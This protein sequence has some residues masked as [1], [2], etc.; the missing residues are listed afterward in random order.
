MAEP[1]E[2]PRAE[3][4]GGT[5]SNET[6][7]NDTPANGE[8]GKPPIVMGYGLAALF[9]IGGGIT[10]A[11]LYLAQPILYRIKADF[12]LAESE[13]GSIV[14]LEQ[15]GYAAGLLFLTP[16]G[17]LLPRKRL[18]LV[19]TVITTAFNIL[20]GV[21]VNFTMFQIFSFLLGLSTVTPQILMPFAADIAPP[22]KR[23]LLM[24]LV[25]TGMKV[26]SLTGRLIS[27]IVTQ[28][29]SWRVVFLG[30]GVL[31]GLL[32]VFYLFAMPPTPPNNQDI[33]YPK[34]LWSLVTLARTQPALMQSSFISF[35]TFAIFSAFWTCLTFLLSNPPYNYS[36]STIG[37]FSL[38]G[39]VGMFFSTAAGS[40]ADRVG[41]MRLIGFGI[42]ATF[43]VWIWFTPTAPMSIA[44]VVIG[45]FAQEVG[46]QFIHLP[47]QV[48]V[49][50]L[51][52]KARSRLNSVYM[53]IG[54]VGMSV[55][56]VVGVQA[57]VHGGWHA[58][59][60]T[61]LGFGGAAFLTWLALGEDG[62]WRFG[63]K[64][65][66]T[67]D[68]EVGKVDKG[69]EEE[70]ALDEKTEVQIAPSSPENKV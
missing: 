63:K 3:T 15:G 56:S 62:S 52:P 25:L 1:E 9:A 58:V 69:S 55:G 54:F 70:L 41:P 65:R 44:A 43:S 24:G 49:F 34:L 50:A 7:S 42:M 48:R 4:N 5:A 47:N 30:Q 11:N 18:I 36:T 17:D 23:G 37:L 57:W 64:E 67:A 19:L 31:N 38:I 32:F 14:S 45:C 46:M 27:G 6:P 51:V 8:P 40:I 28:Y 2:P 53:I 59:G 21:S 68:A 10:V 61:S 60:Y 33:S 26:G 12:H 39:I 20:R 13:A 16:L 66:P 22:A 35:F 29:F